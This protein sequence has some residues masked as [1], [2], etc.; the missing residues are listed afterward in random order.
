MIGPTSVL[1]LSRK[2]F[3]ID[4]SDCHSVD[5]CRS[6]KFSPELSPERKSIM[7]RILLC[8]AVCL[9]VFTSAKADTFTLTSGAAFTGFNSISLNASGPNVSL[10]QNSGGEPG[11]LTFATCTPAPCGPGSVLNVGGVFDA[12]QL[13]IGFSRGTAT[14]NGVT[15]NDI[16]L[17]G[18]LTFTGSIVLPS[19][20]GNDHP[21]S[22]PFSMQG[23]LQGF[24]ACDP[25]APF[26]PCPTPVFDITVVG[27]GIASANF[28]FF[29]TRSVSYAFTEPVPE[30]ATLG[31]FGVGVLA[32]NAVRKRR[33]RK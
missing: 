15:F 18:T 22:V 21:V 12:N 20:F 11:N 2:K 4:Q 17:G 30:P 9:F 29:G 33:Q 32:L 27:S 7:L 24:I 13:N 14:I 16:F 26:T 31:V 3:C 25:S 8:A 19:D 5:F 10:H 28:Q 23:Q 6:F 1:L